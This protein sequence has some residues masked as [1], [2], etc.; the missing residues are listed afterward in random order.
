VNHGD[1]NEPGSSKGP[2]GPAMSHRASEGQEA[3][4][5]WSHGASNEPDSQQG[6][7]EPAKS[8]G[9]SRKPA[10]G[11]GEGLGVSNEPGSPQGVGSRQ[12]VREPWT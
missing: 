3:S 8:Q 7:R 2:G 11:Q 6:G 5:E 10:W 4:N 1:S 12:R 9:D